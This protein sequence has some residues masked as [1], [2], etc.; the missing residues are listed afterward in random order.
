MTDCVTCQLVERRDAGDSPLWDSILR[1]HEWDVVHAFGVA[2]EGWLV[3]VPRRHITSVADLTDD[4]AATLGP[5]LRRVSTAL[6]EVMGCEKTYVV[7]FA[8][9]PNHPHV[10]FHVIARAPDLAP[11]HRGPGIFQLMSAS[12]A[13][14]VSEGRMNEIAA[15]VHRALAA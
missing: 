7:Q 3:L 15:A 9:H 14:P 6:Q 12:G 13:E 10:H 5:M 2:V 1:T 11:E 4:E 8:E